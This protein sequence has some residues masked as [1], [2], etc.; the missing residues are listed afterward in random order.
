MLS[1]REGSSN[2]LQAKKFSCGVR[3]PKRGTNLAKLGLSG[4]RHLPGSHGNPG[5]FYQHTGVKGSLDA[6]QHSSIQGSWPQ[7]RL[8]KENQQGQ[9]ITSTSIM[10]PGKGTAGGKES[11][12]LGVGS[13]ILTIPETFQSSKPHL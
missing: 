8:V 12:K 10:V 1:P 13:D 9:K 4:R 6:L 5:H 3:Y 11:E 7:T 2:S